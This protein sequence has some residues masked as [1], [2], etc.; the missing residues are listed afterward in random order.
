MGGNLRI[1][2]FIFL[3]FLNLVGNA[4]ESTVPEENPCRVVRDECGVELNI[5]ADKMKDPN[6]EIKMQVMR[7]TFKKRGHLPPACEKAI[8]EKIAKMSWLQRR[9]LFNFVL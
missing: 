2:I 4:E 9:I 7:C 1:T 3:V 8:D 6:R 5:P